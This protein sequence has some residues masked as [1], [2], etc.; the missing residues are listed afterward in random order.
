MKLNRFLGL[1]HMGASSQYVKSLEQHNLTLKTKDLKHVHKTWVKKISNMCMED[2]SQYNLTK[3]G[4]GVTYV[5]LLQ[6]T[7]GH[8]QMFNM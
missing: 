4:T 7:F 3:C 1:V 5:Y 2:M 6:P 8:A